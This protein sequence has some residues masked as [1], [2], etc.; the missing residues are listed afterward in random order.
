MHKN[1]LEQLY[2]AISFVAK[3]SKDPA[4]NF[5]SYLFS[6]FFDDEKENFVCPHCGQEIHEHQVFKH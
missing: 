6:Y 3:V 1:T 4:V 5:A 2:D